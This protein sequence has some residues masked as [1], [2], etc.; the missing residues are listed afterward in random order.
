MA[1]IRKTPKRQPDPRLSNL[2][3]EGGRKQKYL[4]RD[5]QGRFVLQGHEGACEDA[6]DKTI[7]GEM[8]PPATKS[9]T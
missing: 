4:T 6:D 2:V 1:V 9:T 5:A 3:L 7:D 8:M